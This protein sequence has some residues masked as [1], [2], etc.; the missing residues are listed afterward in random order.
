MF[1]GPPGRLSEYPGGRGR[2]AGDPLPPGA[3]GLGACIAAAGFGAG[4]RASQALPGR[5]G[6][7]SKGFSDGGIRPGRPKDAIASGGRTK[8]VI[9]GSGGPPFVLESTLLI[10]PLDTDCVAARTANCA[11]KKKSEACF[12]VPDYQSLRVERVEEFKT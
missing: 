11:H 9:L 4:A 12:I 6:R 5:L 3:L 10:D 2:Q 8:G 7:G 1:I